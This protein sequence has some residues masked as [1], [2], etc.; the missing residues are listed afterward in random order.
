MNDVRSTWWVAGCAV[1]VA[2]GGCRSASTRIYALEPSAPASHIDVYQ[3][4]ALRVDT[5]TVPASWDRSEILKRSAAGTLQLGD[6]DHWAA[7]LDQMARQ[8]LSDDLDQRLPPGSVIYPRLPKP[9]SALGVNVDILE[10]NIVASQASMRASWIIVPSGD[11]Q[12]A[13][14]SAAELRSSMS[15]EDPA[16]VAQ[17]WSDL[18]GKLADRIAAAAASFNMPIDLQR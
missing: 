17:A 7:P 9:S 15:S 18:I 10:F 2:L 5:L 14:R 8:T 16:A 11:A 3:A 4:P 6:F 12:S 13:K 1:A